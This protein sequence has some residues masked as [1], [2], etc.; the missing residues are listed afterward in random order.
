MKGTRHQLNG[1][2]TVKSVYPHVPLYHLPQQDP[3][4]FCKSPLTQYLSPWK[5]GGVTI[6]YTHGQEVGESWKGWVVTEVRHSPIVQT[7]C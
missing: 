2:M 7:N 3:Y 1:V 5:A 4:I 6:L